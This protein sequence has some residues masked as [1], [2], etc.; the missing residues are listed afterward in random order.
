MRK[1]TDLTFGEIVM[2]SWPISTAASNVEVTAP[3]PMPRKVN[4]PA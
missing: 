2:P 1:K 4:L 3:R